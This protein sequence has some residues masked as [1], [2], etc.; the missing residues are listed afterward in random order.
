MS[1]IVVSGKILEQSQ[2][3]V[4]DCMIMFNCSHLQL[5]KKKSITEN[6]IFF[7]KSMLI[8][9]TGYVLCVKLSQMMT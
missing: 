8:Q 2:D 5:Q 4:K 1:Y 9:I 6:V 7:K 3:N